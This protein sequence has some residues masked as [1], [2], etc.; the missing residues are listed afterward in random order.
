M[1][2]TDKVDKRVLID[3]SRIIIEA[4]VRAGADVFIGY[5]I[6]PANLLY[7][8]ATQRFPV[9][10]AAPDEIT[11]VQ[12][13]AG[14]SAT[15][16]TPVTA[17]SFP[18]FALMIESINMALMMELPMVIILVQRLGPSTGT[19]T[20]GAQGDV[21]L[22]RGLISGGYPLPTLC[23]SSFEDCW[24]LAAVAV[25]VAIQLRTPVI[26]LTSKEMVMT[27]RSFDKDDLPWIEPV[28]RNLYRGEAPYKPFVADQNLVPPFLPLGNKRHQVRLTAST[29]DTKGLL[30]HS[31]QEALANTARLQ[32]KIVRA[33]P[34]YTYYEL[35]EAEGADSLLLTYGITSGAAREAVQTLRE[36]GFPT[37]LLIAK[38]L[39]PTPEDYYKIIERYERV[40]IAEENLNA[41]YCQ[42]LFG[43]R[44]PGSVKTVGAAGRMITPHELVEKMRG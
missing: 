36:D 22:L 10:L 25:K 7:R 34:K 31:T 12:W 3:G 29:H 2:L 5:P 33:L 9:V 32:E 37:S 6:T 20:C 27:L 30:Q 40:L 43:K 41:Q 21:L 39:I 44:P 42:I 4:C 15:G 1:L 38:T 16:K 17:T 23:P 13:M 24:N 19:A 14:L 28:P 26:L 8:Y 11:T 35:D 18:G